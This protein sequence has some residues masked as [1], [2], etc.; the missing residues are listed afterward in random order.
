MNKI[1]LQVLA[2]RNL[3]RCRTNANLTQ[4]QVAEKVGISTSFYTNLE[5]GSRSMSIPVLVALADVLHVSTDCILYKESSEIHI[6]NICNLLNDKPESFI[7]AAEGV[8]CALVK[9]FSPHQEEIK[10]S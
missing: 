6:A 8:L 1:D 3:Q 9:G 7:I 5:R 10:N 2:G 4:E